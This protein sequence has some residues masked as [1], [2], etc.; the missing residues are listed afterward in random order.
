MAVGSVVG[1]DFKIVRVLREDPHSTTYE[2]EQLSTGNR[3]TL[4]V[5]GAGLLDERLRARFEMEAKIASRIASD[6]VLQVYGA[7]TDEATGAPFLVGEMLEGETLR[8]R[9]ERAGPLPLSDA[10]ELFEQLFHATRAAHEANV[11]HRA[12]SPDKVFL[13]RSKRMGATWTVKVLDFGMAGVLSKATTAAP[14][15]M[16]FVAPE[17]TLAPEPG[18]EPTPAT[19]VFS[20][21]LLAFYA[22]VG[23][24]Y[25]TSA[26]TGEGAAATLRE[27]LHDPMPAA[28]ERA[29]E[30]GSDVAL[31][32]GFDAVFA[33][34]TQRDPLDRYADAGA[35]DEA[36]SVVVSRPPISTVLA[37]PARPRPSSAAKATI[38]LDP[39]EAAFGA[40]E[41]QSAG[42]PAAIVESKVVSPRVK[43]PIVIEPPPKPKP[44]DDRSLAPYIVLGVLVTAGIAGGL[45]GI[46]SGPSSRSHAAPISASPATSGASA[47]SSATGAPSA[48]RQPRLRDSAPP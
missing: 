24:P 7:G 23:K 27:L 12:L 8:E 32:A 2:A 13:A 43:R 40:E 31:P 5:L 36:L 28:S 20:L 22:L 1:R 45:V 33:R 18:R 39:I 3:R 42:E 15:S 34:A 9:V 11:L 48:R 30:L 44:P 6:H 25:W 38:A 17:Q 10:A 21:G 4:K 29:A 46:F 35:L 47:K 41:P 37:V 19:D 26:S 14:P 16:L